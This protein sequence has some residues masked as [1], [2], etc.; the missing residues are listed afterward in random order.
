MLYAQLIYNP[1]FMTTSNLHISLSKPPHSMIEMKAGHTVLYEVTGNQHNKDVFH[2][3]KHP[4]D[5]LIKRL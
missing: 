3:A 4:I 5:T 2:T 1:L